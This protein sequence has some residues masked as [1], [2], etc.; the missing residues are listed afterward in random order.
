MRVF[1]ACSAKNN[2]H[3]KYYTLAADV[4]TFLAKR[5]HKLVFGGFDSGMMSKCYLTFKYEERPIKGVADVTD[6]LELEKLELNASKVMP[7]TFRRTEEIFKS[8]DLIIILPGGFGTFG[9]LFGCIDEIRTKNS[10]KH[11]I[12][13]NYEEYYELL[14]RFIRDSYKENFITEN[15]LKLIDVV[16]DMKSLEKLLDK[17]EKEEED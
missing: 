2:L 5:G 14:L 16:K 11:L 17:I 1:I 8:S 9:E 13:F 10:Q 3:K 12:I 15:D 4:A 7:T 6:A